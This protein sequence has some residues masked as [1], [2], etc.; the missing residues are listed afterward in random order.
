MNRSLMSNPDSKPSSPFATVR[1]S[2]TTLRVNRR[3]FIYSTALAAGA[4]A[5]R[6]TPADA[7][8]KLKSANEKLDIGCIGTGG[9]WRADYDVHELAGMDKTSWTKP[10]ENIVALCDVDANYLSAMAQRFPAARVYKDYR[11]M[12][13]KEKTLDA[14]G[15][16]IPDHQHAPAAMLAMAAGK[17]V[18]CEKPLAHSVWEARQMTLAARKYGVVTQMGNQGHSDEWN[19][20]LC[21]TIA[22]GTI[23]A[24]R[25]VHCWTD[26]AVHVEGGPGWVQGH[27]RPPGSDPIPASFEWDLW[28]GPA[29]SRP[30][31]AGWPEDKRVPVYHPHVWRGWW[32]FGCGAIGDMACHIMD[33]PYWALNL[34]APAT[35]ELVKSSKLMPEMAP[36]VSIIKFQFPARGDMPPCSL[37]WYDGG[38]KPA[39]PA[40]MEAAQLEDNG[41]LLIGDKGKIVA[42]TYGENIRLL[43]ESLM[44]GH[45]WPAQTIP[46]VPGNSPHQDFIR[47]CKGGVAACSNFDV[48]GP[49]TEMALLGNVALRLGRKIEWD[50]VNVKCPG[51]P[52]ADALLHPSFR[53]GWKV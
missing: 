13:D 17:H 23:G 10:T 43:P 35:V 11:V 38:Q 28:L 53:E 18:Y 9:G 4:L 3:R 26:R 7:G 14:V 34:G 16:A 24:V 22:A 42:G 40:E 49:F 29:P 37:T 31:L 6:L 51:T 5:T 12:L 48:S 19:R 1:T 21:E 45:K 44:V 50:P 2:V 36:W 27:D 39:K 47:A 15:I 41:A 46:R 20:R 30:F 33:G 25:E 52:E 8:V 32:D